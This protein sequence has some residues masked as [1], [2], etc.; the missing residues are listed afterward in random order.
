MRR[1]G[2]EIDDPSAWSM[3]V[4]WARGVFLQE[5]GN[6]RLLRIDQSS[7][8]AL[9]RAEASVPIEGIS[10]TAPLASEGWRHEDLSKASGVGTATIQRIEKNR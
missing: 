8:W 7:P 9:A 6:E 3:E 2:G 5:D 1:D 4:V 10:K